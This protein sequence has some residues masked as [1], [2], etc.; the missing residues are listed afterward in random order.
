MV[1][2]LRA[3][4]DDLSGTTKPALAKSGKQCLTALSHDRRPALFR[5]YRRSVGG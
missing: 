2:E 5:L 4:V 3:R 1:T